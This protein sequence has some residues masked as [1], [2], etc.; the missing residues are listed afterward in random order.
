MSVTGMSCSRAR[1]II[2][3]IQEIK[4]NSGTV[5]SCEAAQSGC[6]DCLH[7]AKSIHVREK[8][9]VGLTEKS[10]NA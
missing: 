7:P 8:N 6:N 10:E 3:S 9:I 2:S 5:L 1:R 4:R